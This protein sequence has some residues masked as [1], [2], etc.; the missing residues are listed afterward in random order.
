MDWR[1]DRPR[2]DAHSVASRRPDARGPAGGKLAPGVTLRLRQEPGAKI[3]AARMARGELAL[4]GVS[5]SSAAHVTADEVPE[6]R[7]PTRRIAPP[8]GR[9]VVVEAVREVARAEFQKL[10]NTLARPIGEAIGRTVSELGRKASSASLSSRASRRR[11][12]TSETGTRHASTR[13]ETSAHTAQS[14]TLPPTR[15]R[16]PAV[17]A[18]GSW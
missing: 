10:A 7:H 9:F 17:I 14:G 2:L 15:R 3:C 5:I 1:E 13:S 8:P 16:A 11:S 4:P 12:A 6:S 18:R